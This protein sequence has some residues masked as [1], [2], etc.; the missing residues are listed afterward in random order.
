MVGLGEMTA[1]DTALVGGKNASLGE[2]ISALGRSGIRV[3]DGFAVTAAAYWALLDANDLRPSIERLLGEL[4]DDQGSLQRV[5]AEIRRLIAT[6]EVPST[7]RD[8]I[9]IGYGLVCTTAGIA[10]VGVAV[11]S[12]ATAEDL[13]E[14]SFAGQHESFLNVSGVDAVV[15]AVRDCMASLFTDRAISYRDAQGFAQLQVALSVGVQRMVRS[16]LG[17]A[18]VMFTLDTETGFPDVIQIDAAWGL[19]ETVVKGSVSPDRYTVFKPFL[20][21]SDLKPVISR[22]LGSKADKM[23]YAPGAARTTTVATT[24]NERNRFVLD[25]DEIVQLARWAVLIE[26]HYGRPMDIEWAKDGVTGEL[27]IVQARPETVQTARKPATLMS[28]RLQRSG[29][30]LTSGVAIG[31]GV[32]IGKVQRLASSDDIERFIPGSVLVTEMTDPD[33]V[34]I[35][36]RAAAIVTD[37]GG[38]TSHAAIVSRELGLSAVIG[39]GDATSVLSE[40]QIV[41]VSCAEGNVGFVYEGASDVA[42]TEIDLSLLPETSTRVMLNLGDPAAAMRWWRLGADGVGLARMEFIVGTHIK[43]HPMALAHP[44]QVDDERGRAEIAELTKGFDHPRDYFVETLAA[45]IAGI[46]APMFPKPVIVRL[47]DFKTNEYASLIG[48]AQFE[49][50]EAN[51]MIGWRGASRYYD[52]GYRDGFRL[53]CAAVRRVRDEMG[54][55]NVI[56]MIPFCRTLREADLV[57]ET[58]AAEGLQRGANNLSIYVMAEIPSNFLLA[59]EFCERFDGFSI[60]SNDLTQLVLGI[61]RDSARLA[62][63]FDERNPAVVRLIRELIDTAHA[64]DRVVGLCGQAPSDHPEFARQLVEMGIDSISVTPDSFAAVRRAVA[65]AE[66]GRAT[67][68]ELR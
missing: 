24:P 34:P 14:A 40:G 7:L 44:D 17:A 26:D 12:S 30:R 59:A 33:W 38:R 61:D 58:M 20:A 56:V 4:T 60:G 65:T 45:G 21:D 52:P 6:A 62:P 3:P 35:M 36:R 31:E 51:P 13:P 8:E 1:A 63:N 57:L 64:H 9:A 25:I 67:R 39:T 2:M 11:R 15:G 50:I 32:A 68:K 37:R 27:F 22:S 43:A 55:D 23:I 18:G 5:G 42:A 10:D 29:V 54:F 47:S 28:Y 16:D 48:G 41:T 49:P 46:A 19:G 66:D 53:E